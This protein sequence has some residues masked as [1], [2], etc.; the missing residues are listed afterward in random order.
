MKAWDL[1]EPTDDIDEFLTAV[2][3][4]I[5]AMRTEGQYDT[6]LAA[7]HFLKRYQLGELGHFTLDDISSPIP[8]HKS[9]PAESSPHMLTVPPNNAPS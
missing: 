2:A 1:K 9:T 8:A 5:R 4:R 7:V 3:R 6:D